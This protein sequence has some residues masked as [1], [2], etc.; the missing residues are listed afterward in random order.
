MR[1]ANNASERQKLMMYTSIEEIADCSMWEGMLNHMGDDELTHH[2][3]GNDVKVRSS[4]ATSLQYDTIFF[5]HSMTPEVI[6]YL[7]TA[8][9]GF[10][11]C[12]LREFGTVG[13]GDSDC[14]QTQ[15]QSL[16]PINIPP[17]SILYKS[18]W[19]QA[20]PSDRPSLARHT[21]IFI[22]I[23]YNCSMGSLAPSKKRSFLVSF[24]EYKSHR[25]HMKLR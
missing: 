14:R 18:R 3:E 4:F 15:I 11:D 17:F 1:K 19:L 6:S 2:A 12:A 13:F 23:P 9:I 20:V 21:F 24:S 16:Y 7:I 25:M 22:K 10:V 5:S 8:V